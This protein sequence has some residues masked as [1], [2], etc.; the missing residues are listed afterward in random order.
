MRERPIL[1]SGP[2]V[3]ALL[4]GTKTQTRRTKELEYF[5]DPI[6]DPAGWWCARVRDGVAYMV[7]KQ[8]P[9]ELEVVCPH[10]KPGDRLWV[11]EA[12]RTLDCFDGDSGSKIADLS[13][14]AGYSQPWAP[15]QYEANGQRINWK[16]TGTPSPGAPL[17]PGRYRHAR[18]MPRWAS[19][20]TLEITDVRVERLQDISEAD[21]LAEGIVQLPD[22]GF[23]L[24]GGEHYHAADPRQA[25]FSLWESLNGSGSVEAN[26]WLWVVH[27]KRVK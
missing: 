6:Y 13:I 16:H 14:D 1:F 4:E 8:T 19:R 2:M 21:A 15:L 5:S 20:T 18:F 25:Y 27:F 10:G 17:L 11:R 26:P 12:W 24:D 7:Y 3:R 23:G 22:G 9:R